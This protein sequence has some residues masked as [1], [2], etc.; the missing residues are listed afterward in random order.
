MRGWPWSSPPTGAFELNK[1]SPQ[2]KGL[3]AWFPFL[4]DFR[5]YVEN[6]DVVLNGAMAQA[7]T[8]RGLTPDFPGAS[9]AYVTAENP[10]D[11]NGSNFTIAVWIKTT[12]ANAVLC[13]TINGADGFDGYEWS[14]SEGGSVGATDGIQSIYNG[15]VWATGTTRVDDGE[16]HLAAVTNDGTN[17]IFYVDGLLDISRSHAQPNANDVDLHIGVRP[18][19]SFTFAGQMTNLSFYNRSLSPPEM[20]NLHSNRFDLYRP[21]PRMFVVAVEVGAGP[22]TIAL[23]TL[24]LAGSVPSLTVAPGPV[25]LALNTLTLAG[26]VEALTVVPGAVALALNTL[27]L[28]GS[29][30][31][32]TVVPG[33]VTLAL[34]TLTL[35]GS[36]ESLTVTIGQIIALNTLTLAGSVE[37]LTVV[38]GAVTM[39]LNT[40]TL[41]GSVEALTVVPGAVTITLDTVTLA[42]SAETLTLLAVVSIALNT[43][44]LAGSV[45]AGSISPGAVSVLLDSITLASSSPSISLPSLVTAIARTLKGQDSTLTLKGQ[46][47]TLTLKDQQ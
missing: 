21:L 9:T 35:A 7:V 36:A 42:G 30:E 22:Q 28:A 32:L 4:G 1:F 45:E 19:A 20:W 14:L 33:A 3:V 11:F 17:T 25:A 31:A 47:S 10:P 46:D 6:R 34:N 16:W 40:L 39:A 2:A 24:T 18:N 44:T 12:D 43:L 8:L 37:A 41:A 26:S 23:N 13:S 15:N 27:T 38:P 29:V 5:E